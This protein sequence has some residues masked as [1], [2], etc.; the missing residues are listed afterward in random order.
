[1]RSLTHSENRARAYSIT[2]SLSLSLS[3][4]FHPPSFLPRYGPLASR[5]R[6]LP[7]TL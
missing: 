7:P 1:M 3:F 4:F 6:A 2:L 5:S